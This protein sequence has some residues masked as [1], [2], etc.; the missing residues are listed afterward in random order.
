M[1]GMVVVSV[2]VLLVEDDPSVREVGGM[3]ILMCCPKARVFPFDSAYEASI[4]VQ[5]SEKLDLAVIDFFTRDHFDGY[6]LAI[7]LREKYP[8]LPIISMSGSSPDWVIKLQKLI[9]MSG[10]RFI[11][12]P[13]NTLEL[14]E[15]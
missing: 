7:F 13:F 4:F 11:S 3:Q 9:R 14:Q 10:V 8:A 5:A 6:D 2:S 15:L 1:Y 12:K